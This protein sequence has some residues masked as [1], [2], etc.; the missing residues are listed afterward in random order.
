MA[1]PLIEVRNLSAYYYNGKKVEK[2]VEGVSFQVDQG[3]TVGIVGESGS[4]KTT[5]GRTLMRLLK[6][7]YG[8]IKY[9][10]TEITH[11]K[12][13]QLRPYKKELQMIF[14]NPY[15]SL[16]PRMKVGEIIEEPLVIQKMFSKKERTEKAFEMIEKVGLPRSSYGKT[17]HEFSGGQRQRIAIARAL[18]MKP[19][20]IIADEPVSALDVSVQAQILNLLKDLQREYSLTMIFISHDLS[21]VHHMSDRVAVLRHGHLLEMGEKKEIY[22]NPLHPYTRSL[23]ASIPRTD[24]NLR[25]IK[26]EP[27]EV[28]PQSPHPPQLI[29]VENGHYVAADVIEIKNFEVSE[30][31]RLEV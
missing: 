13:Q 11:M 29:D 25:H 6:P 17:I 20:L 28:P 21:V 5:L 9:S 30:R 26:Q 24:P 7:D 14:Q 2:A 19:K 16:S 4:G 23:L 31:K 27:I 1:K 15:E 8:E 10:G 18:I 3:E 22:Q 12:E